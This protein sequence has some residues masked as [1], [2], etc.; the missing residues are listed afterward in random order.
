MAMKRGWKMCLY[1]KGEERLKEVIQGGVGSHEFT[2]LEE[3]NENHF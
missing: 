2:E 3:A 1:L